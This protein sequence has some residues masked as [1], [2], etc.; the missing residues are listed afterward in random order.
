[1]VKTHIL[2]AA[3]LLAGAGLLR[4][5][6]AAPTFVP[7]APL[8][9]AP[10]FTFADTNI[11]PDNPAAMQ[12]GIP[13]RVGGGMFNAEH[14]PEIGTNTDYDGRF[15]GLRYVQEQWAFG[16]DTIRMDGNRNGY[17]ER[18]DSAA[19]SYRLGTNFA[20]GAS[21][22]LGEQKNNAFTE[23]ENRTTA[24]LALFLGESVFIGV[25]IGRDGYTR[26][27]ATGPTVDDSRDLL[28]A[29]VGFFVQGDW[30]W[31]LAYD[32]IDADS[33]NDGTTDF[34]AYHR[35]EFRVQ[36]QIGQLLLAGM[37]TNLEL[38][39]AD[40]RVDAQTFDLGWVPIQGLAFGLRVMD[41]EERDNTAGVVAKDSLTAVNVAYLF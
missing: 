20:I 34:G 23:E 21:L 25:G 29:G 41:S 1:M 27:P 22:R 12:W 11:V 33:Y 26:T 39:D 8:V 7:A 10:E 15:F 2:L 19:L 38:E 31:H 32:V 35:D 14:R 16:A 5:Q 37:D 24:G 13:S 17:T 3:L 6:V 4:A 9:L 28:A 36:L 40:G 18:N 30:R